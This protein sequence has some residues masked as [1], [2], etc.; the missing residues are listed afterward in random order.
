MRIDS[1]FPAMALAFALPL[2]ATAQTPAE[3][4][5]ILPYATVADTVIAAPVVTIATIKQQKRLKGSLAVGVPEGHT[6]YL[7][8]ADVTTLLK[9]RNGLPGTVEFL[10]DVRPADTN[11]YARLKGQKVV[12]AASPVENRPSQLQL[13]GPFGMMLWSAPLESRIRSILTEASAG[14][15]PPFI[16][17]VGHAFHVR[18]TLPGESET[19]IF[20]KT[21]NNSPVSLNVL[22]RPGEATRWAVAL[23]ELVDDAA[24]PTERDTLLWYRLACFLPATLPAS[25]VSEMDDGN[26]IAAA[27]DYRFILEQLGPCERAE[28]SPQMSGQPG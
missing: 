3:T 15:A 10:L 18:G 9:G 19:Q 1:L 13:A 26:A 5:V 16:T 21:S 6:R 12:V 11:R 27:A 17:G 7:I 25:S 2:P 20:L 14:N 22:R 23:G 24:A 8:T 4:T 28:T